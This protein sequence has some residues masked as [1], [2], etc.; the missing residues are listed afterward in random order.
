MHAPSSYSY[1]HTIH[2]DS[3]HSLATPA[4]SV[5]IPTKNRL[6]L[7]PR[8][9]ESLTWQTFTDFEVAVVNDGGENPWPVV[10]PFTR[11]LRIV[12]VS[13]EQ[14]LGLS[15]ARNTGIHATTGHNIAYLD[16]DDFYYE[17][18]LETLKLALDATGLAVAYTR[19]NRA[20]ERDMNGKTVTV[21]RRV[22]CSDSFD[23]SGMLQAN[24]T[25]VLCVMHS[26]KCL[27]LIGNFNE[28]LRS[29]EDWD[30]W[31]RF[32]RQYN[33]ASV[34]RTTAEYVQTDQTGNNLST[35]TMM[36]RRTWWHEIALGLCY[37]HLPR[38]DGRVERIRQS[39]V[40]AKA[41][42]G[43]YALSVMLH[44]DA[45]GVRNGEAMKN[46]FMA[47][48][49]FP[50]ETEFV[51]CLEGAEAEAF[52]PPK[53]L[54]DRVTIVLS[55][56]SVGAVPLLNRA[57]SFA[58]GQTLLFYDL[59]AVPDA[60]AVQ[61]MLDAGQR[62][63][64]PC[65]VGAVA[66]EGARQSYGGSQQESG[67]VRHVASGSG[68]SRQDETVLPV[69]CV[70]PALFLVPKTVFRK[71]GGF[72]PRYGLHYAAADLCLRLGSEFGVTAVC[73]KQAAFQLP[74]L[75]TPAPLC[76]RYYEGMVDAAQ[77]VAEWGKTGLHWGWL[78]EEWAVPVRECP[79]K[80]ALFATLPDD[81]WGLPGI[82]DLME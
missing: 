20:L 32:S 1:R 10:E 26:R 63:P 6:H 31:M 30:L 11:Q 33:F 21:S 28:N 48:S 15:N 47:E 36:M 16:D 18:H 59:A 43:N 81:P 57:A 9:L 46:L 14:S 29:H 8:A 77:F 60:G 12:F 45:E 74:G 40:L 7:L 42:S 76:H 51:L 66:H 54:H 38:R 39:R 62:Q 61:A 53:N 73:V 64:A 58:Q 37:R 79:A 65:I 67:L 49:H 27:E 24:L 72:R 56:G 52:R 50:P 41:R 13:R 5:I 25:P 55:Q 19:A 2:S 35:N 71:A 78:E 44:L 82:P 70:H 80:E 17:E 69:D 68:A 22:L 4:V 34:E 3:P 23:P 75:E